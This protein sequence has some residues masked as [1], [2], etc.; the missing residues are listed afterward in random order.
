MAY[1]TVDDVAALY[2]AAASDA[3]RTTALLDQAAALMDAYAPG[4]HLLDPV[5]AYATSIN[6]NM[7]VRAMVNPLGVKSEQLASYSTTWGDTRVGLYLTDDEKEALGTL[8]GA[9]VRGSV[10]DVVTPLPDDGTLCET[11]WE[12]GLWFV[13]SGTRSGV[14]GVV[15]GA[16][17]GAQPP[18]RVMRR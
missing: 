14:R 5:P 18:G 8:P 12:P 2:P 1:A 9:L 11:W 16:P 3:A 13:T 6:A 15:R 4:L 7:V 17:I 10:Y